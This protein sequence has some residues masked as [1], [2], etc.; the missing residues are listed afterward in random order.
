MVG[1]IGNIRMNLRDH[2]S[3]K[4]SETIEYNH[5][6]GVGVIDVHG[7]KGRR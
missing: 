6:D 7:Y 3:E 1:I 4:I 2:R 5:Y